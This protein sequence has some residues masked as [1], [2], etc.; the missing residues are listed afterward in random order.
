M[1]CRSVITPCRFSGRFSF[2]GW[3]GWGGEYHLGDFRFWISS[4]AF[5]VS[6]CFRSLYI[7]P[8]LCNMVQ[9]IWRSLWMPR[10][11]SW[12][13]YLLSPCITFLIGF[14]SHP[15][16]HSHAWLLRGNTW[17]VVFINFVITTPSLDS[18][19]DALQL[20]WNILTIQGLSMLILNLIWCNYQIFIVLTKVIEAT[21][22][23][24]GWLQPY[25]FYNLAPWYLS[26]L[27]FL[28][29]VIYIITL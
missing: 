17:G 1:C 3:Y 23:L 18:L 29:D 9:A 4:D 14:H 6:W 13:I 26:C 10:F 8:I 2:H 22:F 19:Y 11:F 21:L 25:N 7:S 28:L 5:R 12:S 20:I 27:N 16:F 15:S 24:H